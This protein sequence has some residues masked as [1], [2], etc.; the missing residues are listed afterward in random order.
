LLLGLS[1]IYIGKIATYLSWLVVLVMVAWFSV[2]G[3]Q[4]RRIAPILGAMLWGLALV[5]YEAVVSIVQW[6]R[7]KVAPQ[8]QSLAIGV[9]LIAVVGMPIAWIVGM[10][11]LNRQRKQSP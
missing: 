6:T 2:R 11:S 1:A 4:S 10:L 3:F 5:T 7:W 9:V 8:W